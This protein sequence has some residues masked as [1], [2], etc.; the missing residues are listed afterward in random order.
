V[1]LVCVCACVCV[2]VCQR[3]YVCLSIHTCTVVEI[4]IQCFARLVSVI[5]APSQKL[6]DHIRK[7]ALLNSRQI[8][9]VIFH[10]LFGRRALAIH[11]PGACAC[12]CACVCAM[13]VMC[14]FLGCAASVGSLAPEPPRATR[15]TFASE[16]QF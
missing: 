11:R 12:V 5:S 3:I 1:S 2:C 10:L 9:T 15:V 14:S 6:S 8:G 4:H 13:C 7:H 16:R